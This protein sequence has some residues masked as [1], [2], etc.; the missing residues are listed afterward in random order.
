MLI[1][2]MAHARR[3]FS[4]AVENDKPRA[5]YALSMFQK[6][7]AIEQTIKDG[8][9][10]PEATLQLR[11]DQPVPTLE[12]LKEWMTAEYAKV[13]PRSPIGQ[14][15]AY[16]LPR[17][18]KLAIYTTHPILKI[19]NNLVENAIR[20][21]AIGRKNYLFAG[22]HDAAQRAAMVYSLFATCRLHHINPY[23]WLRDVLQRMHKH[24]IDNIACLLPQNWKEQ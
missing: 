23:D 13:L 22:S 17:W 7:Y 5:E 12:A 15:I 14:A 9:F 21:V 20:P 3:K 8:V 19:D 24:T 16:C 18:E 11:Q 4:D 6:L 1:H 10:S 2:C